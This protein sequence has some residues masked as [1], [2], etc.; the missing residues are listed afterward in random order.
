MRN[1]LHT[2]LVVPLL[3]AAGCGAELKAPTGTPG[4]RT[5]SGGTTGGGGGTTTSGGGTQ[6]GSSG[7]TVGGQAGGGG[8]ATGG[9]RQPACGDGR[10][11][12]GEA[13]DDGNTASC[14]GCSSDCKIETAAT[15]WPDVDGDGFGDKSAQAQQAYCPPM[16][17]VTNNNDC[18]DTDNRRNPMAVDICGNQIDEDCDGMDKSC[19]E[20][21]F[22]VG[23]DPLEA[24]DEEISLRIRM[25][26]FT[27]KP[28]TG[29]ALTAMDA[30]GKK[31][32]V[33]SES[34]TSADVNTK[35]TAVPVPIVDYE[36]A[37]FDD[38]NMAQGTTAT[39]NT[40]SIEI[41]DPMH[42]L[43]AGLSGT[44]SVYRSESTIQA[45]TGPG[46]GAKIV[47]KLGDNPTVFCFETG[48][49]MTAATVAPARRVGLFIGP[50]QGSN[51][52]TEGASIFGASVHWAAGT[53]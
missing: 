4:S 2:M 53:R 32:V 33:I 50:A 13:C 48:A 51:L 39:Q 24:P 5:P 12:P 38:L 11:D 41:T 31:V 47:A 29:T 49:A 34:V 44:V 35:L 28:V 3:I 17:K 26:G 18:L 15:Y 1:V 43:A 42:A 52:S 27:V 36:P 16:G 40:T 25:L 20:A 46:P 9:P 19:G 22:V 21:L 14:D 37:L 8:T 30:V 6:P 10:I 45:A 23:A 7:G